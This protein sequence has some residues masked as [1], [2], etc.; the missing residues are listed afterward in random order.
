MVDDKKV[1]RWETVTGITCTISAGNYLM[2][3][4]ALTIPIR[5]NVHMQ[6]PVFCIHRQMMRT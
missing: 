2:I 5:L 4:L 6:V 3:K 1:S